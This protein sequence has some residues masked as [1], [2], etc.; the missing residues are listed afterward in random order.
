MVALHGKDFFMAMHKAIPAA[1]EEK[2]LCAR[3]VPTA[4]DQST[5]VRRHPPWRGSLLCNAMLHGAALL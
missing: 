3:D 2:G 5:R 1:K 4:R